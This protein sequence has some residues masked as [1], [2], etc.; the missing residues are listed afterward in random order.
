MRKY[1]IQFANEQY[2][3]RMNG[4]LPELTDSRDEAHKSI[5]LEEA[6]ATQNQLSNTSLGKPR[7]IEI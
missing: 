6:Q 7:V 2:F 5:S 4:S 3:K 1:V